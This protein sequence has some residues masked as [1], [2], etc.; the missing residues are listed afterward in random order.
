MKKI[1][2][3]FLVLALTACGESEEEKQIRQ[4]KQALQQQQQLT[5][6]QAEQ[7]VP[8]PMQPQAQAQ[9]IVVQQPAMQAIPVQKDTTFQDMALGALAGHAI[10]SA[11]SSSGSRTSYEPPMQVTPQRPKVVNNYIIQP[12]PAIPIVEK[13]KPTNP[14]ANL[15]GKNLSSGFSPKPTVVAKPNPLANMSKTTFKH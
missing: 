6:L 14:L 10:S 15:A 1:L 2:L 5:A 9:P 4:L 13:P 11:F 8:V 12:K 7:Q 3:T